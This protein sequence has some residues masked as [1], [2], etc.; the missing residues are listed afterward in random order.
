MIT[1]SCAR[2]YLNMEGA[3][4]CLSSHS[5]IPAISDRKS[6]LGGSFMIIV[7]ILFCSRN[8]RGRSGAGLGGHIRRR[9]HLGLARHTQPGQ[10]SYTASVNK[11]SIA[12]MAAL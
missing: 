2:W 9:Y 1:L 4:L 10:A 11:A 12:R 5:R 3:H 6:T 7:R 8:V